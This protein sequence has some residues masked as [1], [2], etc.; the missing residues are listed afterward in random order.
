MNLAGLIVADTD[1]RVDRQQRGEIAHRSGQRAKHAE[2]RAIIAILGIERI[3]D[4]AAVAWATA[5]QTN[6]ALELDCGGGHQ[7]NA[8]CHAGV[9]DG[10][11]RREIVAAV[12]DQVIS[13]EQVTSIV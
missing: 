8:E 7:R 5:E 9:A 6:L 4:K 13:S 12:D 2:L 10:K 1:D 3:T 11:A